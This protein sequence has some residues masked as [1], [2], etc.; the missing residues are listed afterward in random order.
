MMICYAVQLLL[1][2]PWFMIL[3]NTKTVKSNISF[4]R[5]HITC[6]FWAGLDIK[7]V[8]QCMGD[9]NADSDNPLLKMEQ[10]AQV[11]HS[12]HALSVELNKVMTLVVETM[13]LSAVLL[14]IKC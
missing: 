14:N 9:P 2:K 6:L 3:K 7:K 1:S 12:C 5:T 10:D 4:V 13:L 8:E 11:S